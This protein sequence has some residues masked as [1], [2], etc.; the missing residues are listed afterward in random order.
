MRYTY[1][2]LQSETKPYTIEG[3]K[4]ISY[5]LDEDVAEV[6]LGVV[7]IASGAFEDKNNLMEVIL[8]STVTKIEKG[9]FRGNPFMRLIEATNN[10]TIV[11]T[12]AVSPT[13]TQ[14]GEQVLLG[15]V[16]TDE[17]GNLIITKPSRLRF[18]QDSL[19]SQ[20]KQLQEE[21]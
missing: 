14:V 19:R 6:P 2:D 1:S 20:Y 16:D 3:N 9:A 4:L 7:E 5:N 8:P 15:V 17:D 12:G 10:L 21:Q 13:R 11:E 18:M